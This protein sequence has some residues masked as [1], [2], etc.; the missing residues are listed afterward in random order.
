MKI[1]DLVPKGDVKAGSEIGGAYG[2]WRSETQAKSK[3][4]FMRSNLFIF[5]CGQVVTFLSVLIFFAI[6][7]GK[8]SQQFIESMEWRSVT[9]ARLER[10]DK[11]GTVAGRYG[12]DFAKN[13][14]DSIDA[15]LKAV[16]DNTRKLDVIAAT[17]DRLDKEQQQPK[18]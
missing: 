8:L 5:L 18:R 17:V 12:L 2:D 1:P 14:M 10:M 4:G 9:Q 3:D 13:R 15:R 6:A 7:W 11:D 16:E